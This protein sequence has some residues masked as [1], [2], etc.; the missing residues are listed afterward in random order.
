M[1]LESLMETGPGSSGDVL[2][3]LA[4]HSGRPGLQSEHSVHNGLEITLYQH[5]YGT[6]AVQLRV[7]RVKPDLRPLWP[8]VDVDKAISGLRSR[9]GGTGCPILD[10][11]LPNPRD[12]ADLAGGEATPAD[13]VDQGWEGEP[14]SDRLW[15]HRTTFL[16][17]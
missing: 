12:Q 2:S 10:L 4:C 5:V 14:R 6:A 9:P 13:L 8:V 3:E 17:M 7:P 16:A 11:A 1:P 15:T